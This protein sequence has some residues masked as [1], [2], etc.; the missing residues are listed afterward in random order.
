[1]REKERKRERRFT[2]GGKGRRGGSDGWKREGKVDET[3]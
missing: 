3:A 2:E 1:L